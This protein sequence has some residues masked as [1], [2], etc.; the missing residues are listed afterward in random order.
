MNRRE[1]GKLSS[2]IALG[3]VAHGA[4]AD[5]EDDWK[6]GQGSPVHDADR[7]LPIGNRRVLLE[8]EYVRLAVDS[9]TGAIVEYLIKKTGW[10]LIKNPMYAESLRV[11]AATPECS[12]NP[13]IGA[14]NP[15]SSVKLDAEGKSI[16]L[17]WDR[18]HHRIYRG[19][20]DR[21]AGNDRAEWAGCQ[22][23][24]VGSEQ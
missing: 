20:E 22:F 11:F 7:L 13:A 14:R 21:G 23:R 2:V 19:C 3:S 1:F 10:Q 8:N 12:W 18:L 16:E 24:P 9:S 4:S 15:A 6:S 17:R 5:G